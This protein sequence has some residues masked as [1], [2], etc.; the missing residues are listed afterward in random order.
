MPFSPASKDRPAATD[1]AL[2]ENRRAAGNDRNRNAASRQ[3]PDPVGDQRLAHP[4]VN[5]RKVAGR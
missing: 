5:N 4:G 3:V 2:D 1:R